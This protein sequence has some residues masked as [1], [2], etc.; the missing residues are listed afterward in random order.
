MLFESE[1]VEIG[2]EDGW[3][4]GGTA[5]G[6]SDDDDGRGADAGERTSIIDRQWSRVQT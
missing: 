2:W 3:R 1:Y 5:A 4:G 6:G